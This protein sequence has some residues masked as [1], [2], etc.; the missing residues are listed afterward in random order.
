MEFR[1]DASM[2]NVSRKGPRAGVRGC[3][4][5]GDAGPPCSLG[6]GGRLASLPGFRCLCVGGWGG[7]R[8]PPPRGGGGFGTTVSIPSTHGLGR[9][10]CP[11]S[12]RG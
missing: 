12:T 11:T 9:T 10:S 6:P 1:R 8:Q 3:G 5:G 2:L 4:W 7:L